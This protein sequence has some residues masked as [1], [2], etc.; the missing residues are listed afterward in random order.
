M[1][2]FDLACE[3]DHRFEGWFGSATDYDEQLAKGLLECPVCASKKITKRLSAPRLNFGAEPM[4][5]AREQSPPKPTERGAMQV[6]PSA[7]QL[8]AMW[9]QMA[10]QVVQNTEDV[11]DKFAQEARKIHYEQAPERGIRGTATR[12][13][14]AELADEGITVMALVLPEAAKTTL[15]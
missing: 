12:E 11:G 10:R 1:K 7:E 8:Q 14:A 15:Q 13:E 9:L 6:M 2:V 3:L 4:P 5:M